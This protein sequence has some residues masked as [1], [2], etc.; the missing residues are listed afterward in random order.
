[1]GVGDSNTENKYQKHRYLNDNQYNMEVFL[2]HLLPN[3]Q[4]VFWAQLKQGVP[5]TLGNYLQPSWL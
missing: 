3:I 5:E 1:M 4:G 2:N